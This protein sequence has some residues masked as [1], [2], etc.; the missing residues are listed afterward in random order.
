MSTIHYKVNGFVIFFQN[1][2]R[3]V[4]LLIMWIISRERQVDLPQLESHQ[5]ELLVK[6]NRN[7][8]PIF[9]GFFR[10]TWKKNSFLTWDLEI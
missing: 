3:I 5:M 9:F 4:I 10:S 6:K 1:C 2:K 7:N 8:F